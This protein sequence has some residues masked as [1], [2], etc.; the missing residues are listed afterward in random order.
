MQKFLDEGEGMGVRSTL[1][2]PSEENQLP[3]SL[4]SSLLRIETV[5]AQAS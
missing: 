4:R 2:F 1:I 5:P 3:F